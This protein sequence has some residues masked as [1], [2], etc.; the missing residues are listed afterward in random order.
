MKEIALE[1]LL[2]EM[3]GVLLENKKVS[4][5]ELMERQFDLPVDRVARFLKLLKSDIM[6][7]PESDLEKFFLME[8]DYTHI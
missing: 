5:Q 3:L 7:K 4:F 8:A 2:N 1:K 6:L